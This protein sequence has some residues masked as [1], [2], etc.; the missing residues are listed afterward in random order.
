MSSQGTSSTEQGRVE[1][2]TKVK[3]IP[4]VKE[5]EVE[6]T[7]EPPWDREMISEAARLQLGMM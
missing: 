6:L 7:F 4:A 2:E 1:L 5:V 3:R